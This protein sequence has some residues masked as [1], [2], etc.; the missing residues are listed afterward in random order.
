M[1]A[2]TSVAESVFSLIFIV[3]IVNKHS[4]FELLKSISGNIWNVMYVFLLFWIISEDII[5]DNKYIRGT[6]KLDLGV[7]NPRI[8]LLFFAKVSKDLYRNINH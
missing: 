2:K 6:Q 7:L 1:G 3:V 8:L 5:Q 4:N